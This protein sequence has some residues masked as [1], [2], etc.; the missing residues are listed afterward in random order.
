MKVRVF[1]VDKGEWVDALEAD[2]I[3]L[4]ALYYRGDIPIEISEVEHGEFGIKTDGNVLLIA[5]WTANSI[6]LIGGIE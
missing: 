4:T 6:R 2:R 1:D 3:Q 5:P